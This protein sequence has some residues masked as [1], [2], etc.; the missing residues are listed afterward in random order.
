MQNPATATIH[1]RHLS[2]V[3]RHHARAQRRGQDRASTRR[4]DALG[5]GARHAAQVRRLEHGHRRQR[6]AHRHARAR[7]QHPRHQAA[8]SRRPRKAHGT[9]AL[10]IRLTSRR[11]PTSS[12][13]FGPTAE[14]A[15]HQDDINAFFF[16]TYLLEY[17]DYLHV[18]GDA[19]TA[20]SGRAASRTIIRTRLCRCRRPFTCAEHLLGLEARSPCGLRSQ[21]NPAETSS[22][23][24]RSGQRLR[25]QR[26]RPLRRT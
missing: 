12:N 14:P 15:E 10:T 13:H 26:D 23:R 4:R 21:K 1:R 5:A 17:V 8:V 3:S 19:Y 20:A 16:V 18:A 6:H 24:A 9:S 11:A 25:R 7:Q 2:E 22:G